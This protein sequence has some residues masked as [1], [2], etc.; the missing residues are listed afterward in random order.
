M[1]RAVLKGGLGLVGRAGEKE[2]G[3]LGWN[4]LG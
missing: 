1:G 3:R 2:K 4:G